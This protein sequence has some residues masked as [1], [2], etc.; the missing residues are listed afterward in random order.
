MKNLFLA[1]SGVFGALPGVSIIIGGLFTPPGKKV[2]FGGVVEA[3]GCLAILIL[4]T[5]RD[6]LRKL[7]R[8]KATRTAI[9]LGVIFFFFLILYLSL[10]SYCIKTVQDRG[11]VYY[12]LW[13]NAELTQLIN[14]AGG[15][16]AAVENYG[17]DD[18]IEKT[19]KPEI[20]LILTDIIFLF[21][22][23][24]IFTSITLAFGI[25]GFRKEKTL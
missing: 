2:L 10:A 8:S 11:T 14:K 18:I 13:T 3:L 7:D 24:A 5:N 9:A 16:T 21:T 4:W 12:P 1:L 22:F 23:Q 15:R 19:Q 17:I 6:R 25:L 20:N